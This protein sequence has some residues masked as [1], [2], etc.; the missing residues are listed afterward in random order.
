MCPTPRQLSMWNDTRKARLDPSDRPDPPTKPT[1]PQ[2]SDA[3][4]QKRLE[5][6][7]R[8]DAQMAVLKQEAHD[9]GALTVWSE[10]QEAPGAKETASYV[11]RIPAT[12]EAFLWYEK[13]TYHT[14]RDARHAGLWTYPSNQEE[15]AKCAVFADLWQ[16]GYYMGNG[17]RFGGDWLVYPGACPMLVSG[18]YSSN[19]KATRSDTIPILWPLSI[20]LPTLPFNQWRSLRM[21]ALALPRKNPI[22]FAVG[23][24]PQTK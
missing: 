18:N 24:N 2:L 20:R 7:K 14:L 13:K 12:S 1:P 11:F 10:L 9:N 17:L 6:Q 15:R 23:M 4:L 5:R 3:A 21:D 8:R 19:H 22:S 16:K